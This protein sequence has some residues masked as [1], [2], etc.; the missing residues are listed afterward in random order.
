MSDADRLHA[1]AINVSRMTKAQHL[2]E[3]AL[4]HLHASADVKQEVARACLPAILQASA[5][6]AESFRNGGHLYL[7]G[8][9]GS[10]ADCQHMAAEFVSR[11][12][13]EFDRAALPAIALTTDSSFLTAYSNDIG[14]DG[15]FERQVR[16]L[17]RAGDCLIGISTS[18]SSANVMLAVDA[19]K[20]LGM[21][22]IVLTGSGGTLHGAADVAIAVPS[23]HTQ[24]IQEAHLAIEHIICDL[25]EQELF[26]GGPSGPEHASSR[27]A[28][29]YR[30]GQ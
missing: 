2:S 6:I 9:G 23:T 28:G 12:T 22:T 19:A 29:R 24:Y 21:R 25:V 11:L 27:A 8:N 14:F 10:A 3:R 15:V 13:R 16:A 20:A 17:G 1:P 18:G 30:N 26:V 5:I 4:H 7:C